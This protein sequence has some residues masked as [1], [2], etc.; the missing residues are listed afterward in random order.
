MIELAKKDGY[1][2]NFIGLGGSDHWDLDTTLY[3]LGRG[4]GSSI[5][6]DITRASQFTSRGKEAPLRLKG[7]GRWKKILP[8]KETTGKR[9]D[10]WACW[11]F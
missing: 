3:G 9:V 11:K 5:T 10:F 2:L 6:T 1:K 4:F 8:G 7:C